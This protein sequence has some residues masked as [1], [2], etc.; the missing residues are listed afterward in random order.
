MPTS[1]PPTACLAS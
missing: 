1:H